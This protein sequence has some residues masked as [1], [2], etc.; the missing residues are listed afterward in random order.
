MRSCAST[1]LS[2]Q[3]GG[4]CSRQ[5]ETVHDGSISAIQRLDG[6]PPQ[7]H[8]SLYDRM[9]LRKYSVSGNVSVFHRVICH[10]LPLLRR[11]HSK[12]RRR[13]EGFT[14]K[15]SSSKKVKEVSRN[16]KLVKFRRALPADLRPRL[17]S[18]LF[19][20]EHVDFSFCFESWA[21]PLH[22][23]VSYAGQRWS[24]TIGLFAG[25]YISGGTCTQVGKQVAGFG[26]CRHG[27]RCIHEA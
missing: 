9:L 4:D 1:N 27:F 17:Q 13:G 15:A 26:G 14:K 11:L 6:H 16:E 5:P 24:F 18:H 3:A 22:A 25:I 19:E 20:L 23:I 21:F 12:A 2:N 10:C 8:L 7:R